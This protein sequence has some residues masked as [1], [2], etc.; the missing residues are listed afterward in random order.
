M[1]TLAIVGYS[2][3][4]RNQ[5]P[6][7][8]PDVDVVGLNEEYNFDWW[9][10]KPENVT[11]FF[12]LHPRE[13]FTRAN[14]TNDSKHWEWLQ[15]KHPFPIYMQQKWSDIPSGVAYPL[16][17][18]YARFGN[19][20][21]NTLTFI[22]AW[23]VMEGYERIELYGFDMAS[24][25]EYKHQRP[26][27]CYWIGLCRG[28]GIDLFIPPESKLLKGYARYAYDDVMLGSRQ[29]MEIQLFAAREKLKP[30]AEEV[31]QLRGR[32]DAFRDAAVLYADLI[33]QL[34]QEEHKA[35]EA[36]DTFFM[37]KGWI[38]GMEE[39]EK[40]VDKYIGLSRPIATE[41]APV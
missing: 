39:S 28:M 33:P 20:F 8:H 34:E 19:Y 18:V 3:S 5:T 4:T 2:P 29:E 31:N 14:N 12:Q 26:N 9:K 11:A 41:Q 13:S 32:A 22:I 25:T 37:R 6:W 16:E 23:A 30:K 10:Q 17:K 15:K 7:N 35:V 1:K 27:A 21:T 40:L 36:R 38:K 24:D